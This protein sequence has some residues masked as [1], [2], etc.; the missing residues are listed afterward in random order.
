MRTIGME[1][2]N[3][4]VSLLVE[5]GVKQKTHLLFFDTRQMKEYDEFTEYIGATFLNTSIGGQSIEY[6]G[7]DIG[8]YRFVIIPIICDSPL[9]V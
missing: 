9:S 5:K 7:I 2:F 6:P 8:G 1:F 4:I 3:K